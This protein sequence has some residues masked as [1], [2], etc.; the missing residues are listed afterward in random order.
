M[1]QRDTAFNFFLRKSLIRQYLP[2]R[3]EADQVSENPAV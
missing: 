2:V 1:N 3:I